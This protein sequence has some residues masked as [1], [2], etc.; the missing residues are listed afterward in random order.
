MTS[1]LP[2]FNHLGFK[3]LCGFFFLTNLQHKVAAFEQRN[4]IIRQNNEIINSVETRIETIAT[5]APESSSR[6]TLRFLSSCISLHL[7]MKL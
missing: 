7:L 3:I 2:I 1:S 4:T 6:N 5:I